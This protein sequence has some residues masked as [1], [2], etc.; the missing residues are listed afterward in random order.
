MSKITFI[1]NV[2]WQGAMPNLRNAALKNCRNDS[3]FIAIDGDD[4]LIGKQ[5]LKL[6]NAV[7]QQQ[8]AYVVYSNWISFDMRVGN[9]YRYDQFIIKNN[10]YRK[11]K[12]FH[13][14]QL[15]SYY[16]KLFQLIEDKDLIDE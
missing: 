16:T 8:Q 14:A 4:E 12:T 11:D 5:V 10:L 1:K 13:F 6:Y 3:I 7:Y 2:V 9:S 15:R